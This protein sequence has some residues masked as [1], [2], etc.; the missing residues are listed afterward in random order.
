MNDAVATG[1]LTQAKQ[2]VKARFLQSD[3][4]REGFL[5]QDSSTEKVLI[6]NWFFRRVVA[7]QP[8]PRKLSRVIEE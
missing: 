2:D 7:E 1:F 4:L 3:F 6:L 8:N 5:A